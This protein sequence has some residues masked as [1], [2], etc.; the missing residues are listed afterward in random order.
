MSLWQ[1][2]RVETLNEPLKGLFR[3]DHEPY[4]A[5]IGLSSSD[6][7]NALISYG[8]YSHKKEADE[9]PTPALEFG[10]AFHMAI[11]E[12]ALF[13]KSYVV[14]PDVDKRTKEG[15]AAFAAWEAGNVG[16]ERISAKN[17]D[18]LETL[19]ASVHA[20]PR[21]DMLKNLEPEIMACH[22]CP[23]TGL[24]LKCKSDLFGSAI[25]DFKTALCAAPWEFNKSVTRYGYHISAA[26]YQD[27]VRAVTGETMPFVHVVVEKKPPY[28][29]AFY[30]LNDDYLAEGRKLYRAAMKR[31]LRWNAMPADAK[32]LH[33]GT[34]IQVLRPTS[35]TLYKT[36]DLIEA[37]ES[38]T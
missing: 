3:I 31:I 23:E 20:H 15:K 18:L 9:D 25:V 26:F 19:S 16:K 12:P 34:S 1:H 7:K 27:V 35:A 14:M 8:Y 29:V 5:G 22:T 33:Y 24:F 11:L 2:P 30:T 36:K 21:W 10:R 17:Q 4:H 6:L 13:A 37:V 28:G 32:K 38:D